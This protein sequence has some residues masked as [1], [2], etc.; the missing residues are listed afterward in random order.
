MTYPTLMWKLF[1][2]CQTIGKWRK[3]ENRINIA[4]DQFT[5]ILKCT[6]CN[7]YITKLLLF[8]NTIVG[9][10]L[11]VCSI[12]FAAY[13]AVFSFYCFL[14]PFFFVVQFAGTHTVKII[15]IQNRQRHL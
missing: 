2:N 13:H 11:P 12:L 9:K 1:L 10:M 5:M 8:K 6:L 3:R 7:L 4:G 14:L 15:Q